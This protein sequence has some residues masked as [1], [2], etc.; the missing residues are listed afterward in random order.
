MQSWYLAT[1][2]EMT[3]IRKLT[4]MILFV[5]NVNERRIVM[6]NKIEKFTEV[7][8]Q[9]H[10]KKYSQKEFAKI[11]QDIA[12]KIF[13]S[14]TIDDLIHVIDYK[15]ERIKPMDNFDVCDFVNSE[16]AIKEKRYLFVPNAEAGLMV[17]EGAKEGS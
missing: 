1:N 6:K 3:S 8:S 17:L 9:I 5:I 11:V 15:E 13:K 2:V 4:L 16:M 7:V 12:N 10:I 14:E